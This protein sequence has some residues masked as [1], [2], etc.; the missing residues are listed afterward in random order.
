MDKP[1]QIEAE[2]FCKQW[3]ISRSKFYAAIAKLKDIGFLEIFKSKFFICLNSPGKPES[4]PV[5]QNPVPVNQNPVPVNQNPV[6]VNQNPVSPNTLP[7]GDFSACDAET[8]LDPLDF[9]QDEIYTF[10]DSDESKSNSTSIT[11]DYL[12][13]TQ[14]L[15]TV[16][17]Y[18]TTQELGERSLNGQQ[19]LGIGSNIPPAGEEIEIFEAEIIDSQ[20]EISDKHPAGIK[21]SFSVL[22][23]IATYDRI[24]VIPKGIELLQW[25]DEQIGADVQLYRRS[26]R[27][28]ASAPNDIDREFLSFL[29]RQVTGGKAGKT[30]N[31][32]A[33]IRAMESNPSRWAELVNFIQKWQREKFLSTDEGKA[34][35]AAYDS[36]T[37]PLGDEY[38]Q[39]NW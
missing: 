32:A 38:S 28:L 1:L 20:I 11:Q 6:P 34:V 35:K 19:N 14:E 29:E 17:S 10:P 21:F 30:A 2:K 12:E 18:S 23:T 3:E 31:P 13:N 26:G 15:I 5:N 8:L 24:G 37:S 7:E 27:I 25:A 22:K 36:A 33:W 9:N 4:V 16:E 39:F